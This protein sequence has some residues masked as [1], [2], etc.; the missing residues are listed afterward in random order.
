MVGGKIVEWAPSPWGG[1]RVGGLSSDKPDAG[2]SVG[3]GCRTGDVG[4]VME[5]P[6]VGAPVRSRCKKP[7]GFL[8]RAPHAK[9][10]ALFSVPGKSCGSI[11]GR[12]APSITVLLAAVHLLSFCLPT[13]R[14][15][16][17]VGHGVDRVEHGVEKLGDVLVVTPAQTVFEVC[18]E[19]VGMHRN[20]SEG[21]STTKAKYLR[22]G[23]PSTMS[24]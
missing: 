14:H 3:G 13:V 2:I 10:S 6:V 22:N 19:D 5:V 9:G 21:Q 18:R 15:G 17:V 7:A 16:V 11:L 24:V 23:Y 4:C 20:P 8:P 12:G 1:G